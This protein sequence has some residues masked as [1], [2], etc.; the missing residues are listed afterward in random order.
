ML[1]H[2]GVFGDFLKEVRQEGGMQ[3]PLMDLNGSAG[4]AVRLRRFTSL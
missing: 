2:N 4:F 1:G 3:A